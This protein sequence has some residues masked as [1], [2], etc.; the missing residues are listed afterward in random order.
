MLHVRV[1]RSLPLIWIFRQ[2]EQHF[3][4]RLYLATY[5]VYGAQKTLKRAWREDMD[6]RNQLRKRGATGQD[7]YSL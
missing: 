2:N 3:H 6:F 4:S 1:F 7:M 5:L